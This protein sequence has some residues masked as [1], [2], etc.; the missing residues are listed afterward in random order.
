MAGKVMLWPSVRSKFI[1]EENMKLIYRVLLVLSAI[2]VV[3]N[4]Y[5]YGLVYGVK[6]ALMVLVSIILTREAEILFYTHDKDINRLEAKE[7]IKK[8]YPEMM[9]VIFALL[10]PIGTPLWLV[11]LG[12]VLAT[13]LGKLLFGGF[14]HMIFH[15]SIVGVILVTL[16]WQ[17]LVSGV[18]FATSF[19][20]YILTILFD[21]N[22]FNQTLH[23]G[24]IFDP[25]TMSSAIDLLNDGT[26]YGLGKLFF[27][28]TPGVIASGFILLLTFAFLLFKKAINYMVPT[29]AIIAFLLTT[30]LLNQFDV[31]YTLYYLFSGSFL[32]VAIFAMTDPITTPVPLTGKIIFGVVVGALTVFIRQAEVYEE[33][34]IFA[35][36]FMNMLTPML[37]EIFKEK[38]APVKKVVKENE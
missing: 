15:G 37:N 17:Q 21:N 28:L 10:I 5:L 11:G 32:F 22:F 26:P 20:N 34:V 4:V 23:L 31:S 1:K 8:S 36:L 2:M 7:L 33:G 35:L 14:H 12:A 9:A 24:G 18:S 3:Q 13:L 29:V 25:Q 38:K 27:G 30:L 19:D 16:G 6:L